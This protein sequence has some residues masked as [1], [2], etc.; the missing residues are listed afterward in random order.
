MAVGRKKDPARRQETRAL[1]ANGQGMH[2]RAA[3]RVGID[4]GGTFT[5]FVFIDPDGR[6][7]VRKRASTPADPSLSILEGLRAAQ[8]EGLLADRFTLIHGT[9]VATNALLERRGARTALITTTGFRDVLEIGRQTREGLYAFT[10]PERPPCCRRRRDG[11][12]A[13][14]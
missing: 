8:E 7:V 3:D 13:R 2:R 1:A 14:G 12:S 5:D 10:R 6:I 9:T 4:V 11:R